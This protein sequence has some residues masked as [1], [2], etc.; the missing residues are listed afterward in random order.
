MKKRGLIFAGLLTA[1]VLIGAACSDKAKT[2]E[3]AAPPSASTAAASLRVALDG[4]FKEHVA[5]AAAATENALSGQTKAFQAAAAALDA[6]SVDLS[7]AVGSVYGA[8]AEKAFLPLWR[9]HITFVVDYTSNFSNKKKQMNA[10][11][12]LLQYTQTFGA[13]LAGANPNLTKDAVASLVKDHILT[14]KDVIDAQYA[15]N[16]TKAYTALRTAEHH[17]EMISSALADAIVK[18]FP[19]K[20]A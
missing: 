17:M 2:S 10:V 20:F 18:Q 1:L 9:S 4:L 6:N 19:A 8:D 14:L 11:D 7:K 15:K 3:T 5:L 16:Y 12:D 13:F